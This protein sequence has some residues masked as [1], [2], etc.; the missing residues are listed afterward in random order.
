MPKKF[1]DIIPPEK[2]I[3]PSAKK[4]VAV[5]SKKVP[6]FIKGLIFCLV[7]LI[8]V[9]IFGFFFFFKV[10]IEIWPKTDIFTLEEKV[11]LDL[12]AKQVDFEGKVIP[13]KTF[14]DY[15]SSSQEFSSSG[16]TLKRAEGKIRLYNK[17]TTAPETWRKG[18]RF[19]STEGKMFYS[20]SRIYVPGA[21]ME[22][23]KLVPSY[24]DVEVVAAEAGEDYNIPPSKFAVYVYRGT[25]RY[26]A[27][28]G[29]SS[30]PM[31]GGGWVSQV[32]QE[33]LEKAENILAEELKKESREFLKA[34]LPEGFV[35]IEETF[36]QEVIESNSSLEPGVEA[37][38]FNFQVK[39]KSQGLGFKES[40]LEDFAKNCISLNLEEGKKF[41]D[42]VD[43]GYQPAWLV[44]DI[45]SDTNLDLNLKIKVK[46]YPEINEAELK[47]ALLGKSLKEARLFLENLAELERVELKS[48]PFLRKRIPD[49]MDKVEIKL[50][51]D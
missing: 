51:L 33:D 16:K 6:P 32:T 25:P 13:A 2:I 20:K 34:A 14:A 17:Y 40:D 4:E 46:I 38:T 50:R 42:A 43:I 41:Q 37:E 3:A 5:E 26:T 22:E 9:G 7:L 15:K 31:A 11:T 45:N 44:S 36:S 35:L 29:E 19:I 27:Y 39:V 30:E 21:K 8:L 48:W 1:F 10:E 47:K 28:W 23:G 18:T 12:N 24:T 49:D